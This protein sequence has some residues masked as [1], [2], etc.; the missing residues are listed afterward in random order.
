[1]TEVAAGPP[2]SDELVPGWLRRLAAIGWR[3]L[4]AIALGLVLLYIAV[5]LATVTTSILIAAIV[6]ATFAP[7]VLELRHR[8]WS[9]IKAAA[10]VFLG[11]AFVILGTL[12]V[13]GLAFLPYVGQVVAAMGAGVA[14]L[15]ARLAELS[16]P[17][18]VGIAVD[19][20]VR[21]VHGWLA[22]AASGIAADIGTL[23][24]VGILATF[25]T[26]FFMM[27][28]DKAWVWSLSSANTW[29][30]DAISSSGHIALERV[31]GYLRGTAVIAAFDA[32]AEGV[33]LVL[34]GVPLAGPLA[35]I[36][37]FGRFIPYIGGFVTTVL[38]LLVTLASQGTT[39]ALILLIL[40]SI[41]NIIQGKF[42]APVIYHKTVDIHPALALIAL[43]AGAALA[44]MVGLFAAI[45]VVAFVLAVSSAAISVLGVEP[46]RGAAGHDQVVPIWLD[47]LGQ[48][49]WRLLVSLALLGVAIAAAVQVPIVVIPLVLGIVLSAT[50]APLAAIL[51]RRGWPAGRAALAATLGAT[52]A[53]VGIIALT[54]VSLADSADE[55]KATASAGAASADASTGGNAGALVGLADRFGGGVAGTV[56]SA[57][58][59]LAGIG[60]IVL[61]S[62][63]LTYYFMRDGAAYW[64]DFLRRVEPGRRSRIEA[65]GRRAF[66]V[67][68]GYMVGTGAISLFGAATQFLIMTILG[69]PY[70]LPLAVLAVFGGFIPYIG[71][72][73]TTGLAFLVTVATGSPTDI[74]I[75]AIFTIVFNIVQGNFVAPIVYSKVV[76]L[77]P[78]VVL[79]AIPAGNEIAGVIG[80]FLVVPFLGVVSAV[81]RT[82]LQVLD[83]REVTPVED[84]PATASVA[85]P[86][87][88]TAPSG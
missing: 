5:E 28:G 11:A 14:T 49:S 64:H 6:A 3:L 30:R 12:V 2:A 46:A 44:G 56:V 16:V 85:E 1:M 88:S 45:P 15:H 50:L 39:A 41:L 18:G 20:V 24:T 83:T 19:A 21:G 79:V 81:W 47:R 38:L 60:V 31:G 67:L 29:R 17:P 7:Y 65:A 36:V 57:I 37:F 52:V 80:M 23:A 51:R 59:S 73:I 84:E 69:L 8:G 66:G 48:I 4:A 86:T 26:F 70:A 58:S 35:V 9:R 62:V 34:L 22:T 55:I 74:A 87:L 25:L 63:L 53:V 75:M 42:L 43:P 71:S 32:V 72:L 77:H 76:S 54:V 10:A 68:G 61:L 13:L 27:D 82:V 78:A 33:F 40:I